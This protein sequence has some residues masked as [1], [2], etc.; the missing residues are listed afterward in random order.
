MFDDT[1]E[2]RD[3][4]FVTLLIVAVV[5]ALIGIRLYANHLKAQKAAALAANPVE[6]SAIDTSTKE[7]PRVLHLEALTRVFECERDGKR[8]L[9]DRPCGT[10]VPIQV[11]K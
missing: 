3:R 1:A 10:G 2:T 6:V 11:I 8:V 4:V 5:G 9:T 7:P